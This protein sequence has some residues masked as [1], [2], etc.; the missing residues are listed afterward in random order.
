MIIFSKRLLSLIFKE[1]LTLF[2]DPKTRFVLI[3]PPIL[4]LF[5]FSFAA[6]LEVKNISVSVLNNDIGKH[7]HEIVQRISASQSFKNIYFIKSVQEFNTYI[8]EQKTIAGIYIPQDFSR[9][10]ESGSNSANIE[11][12]LDGR[13]SNTSQI[14]N[15]Y[16]LSLINIYMS[17]LDNKTNNAMQNIN[18]VVRNWFNPN[19]LYM[20]STVPSMLAILSMLVGLIIT[21]LSVA[22][23]RE[24]GTFDQ[25][26]VSP[27]LPHEILIG[28][29]IPALVIGILE[30]CMICG[31]GIWIF[32]IPF[33]GSFILLIF[34]LFIF[35]LSI[36]GV[37]L[38]ISSL[39]NTQQQSVLGTF[40]FMVPTMTLSGFATPVENM[41]YWLQP[42]TWVNPLKY[43]LIVIKGLYLK[44]MPFI[45]VWYH[46]W[47]LLFISLFTLTI[48]GW[49]FRKKLE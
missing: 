19:L 35:I 6:T 11:I 10:I 43:A 33:V 46:I 47:P 44:D 38:F 36:V 39:S 7:G 2:R 9:K 42:I 14:V 41:P 30:G 24:L 8:D 48:S 37:G 23:E 4:Q 34:A 17:E 45:E 5:V 16:I 31:I 27:L 13:R 22:R 12:I 32:N 20:H 15:S 40:I 21:S 25:I 26:L 28:K 18:I 49:S 3:G 1:I 29:A